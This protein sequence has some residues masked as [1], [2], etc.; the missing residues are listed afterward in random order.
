[1]FNSS[2]FILGGAGAVPEQ[3]PAPQTGSSQPLSDHKQSRASNVIK[4]DEEDVQSW[5]G[6]NGLT[7]LCSQLSGYNGKH[8]KRLHADYCKSR[9][10]FEERLQND[11]GLNYTTRIKF[12]AELEELYGDH[13]PQC[14]IAF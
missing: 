13:T 9:Q 10:K 5:L 11:M 6:E 14:C 3:A 4:W 1:M 8:L 12:M 2:Q 7:E